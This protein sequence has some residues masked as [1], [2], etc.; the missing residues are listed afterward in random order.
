MTK[1]ELQDQVFALTEQEQLELADAIV[2]RLSPISEEQKAVIRRRL[3]TYDV[4]PGSW[5]T[6]DD[7]RAQLE[8]RL[9]N[10]HS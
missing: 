4:D 2:E 9:H 5:L 1:T 8:E 6:W 3:E 7:A 10:Q